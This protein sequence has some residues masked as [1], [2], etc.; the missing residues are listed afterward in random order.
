MGIAGDN[1]GLNTRFVSVRD[2]HNGEVLSLQNKSA[3]RKVR[4]FSAKIKL[5]Y[6]KM[7]LKEGHLRSDDQ[8]VL[9][10]ETEIR[11]L[12]KTYRNS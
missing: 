1:I 5:T 8:R 4:Q 11:I 2:I 10:S 9:S 12:A 7:N 6:E 3:L